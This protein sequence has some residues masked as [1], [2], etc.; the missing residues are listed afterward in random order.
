MSAK[1]SFLRSVYGVENHPRTAKSKYA[2]YREERAKRGTIHR[3]AA[4]ILA[5]EV[6]KA[7]QRRAVS[8]QTA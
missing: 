5:H 6:A 8:K 4:E 1:S 7:E 2:F 3:R